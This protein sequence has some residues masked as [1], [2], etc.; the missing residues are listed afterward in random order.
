METQK[1]IPELVECF[2]KI[3]KAWAENKHQINWHIHISRSLFGFCISE[4][5]FQIT[6]R[7]WL[8]TRYSNSFIQSVFLH[9]DEN[10][11]YN[12]IK[13]ERGKIT[14]HFRND[15]EKENA[16]L[17]IRQEGENLNGLKKL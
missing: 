2:Q 9:K 14:I 8:K 4:N 13:T 16:V 10:G 12:E 1:T 17:L 3:Y 15:Y 6:E 5:F 7:F 11:K